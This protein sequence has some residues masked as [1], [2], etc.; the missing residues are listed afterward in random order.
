MNNNPDIFISY[1][2]EDEAKA[3]RLAT[4]L[5]NEGFSVWWD[6][7]LLPAEN[8]RDQIQHALDSSSV[9]VV[10]WTRES[11]GP[12][13]DFV[14]DEAGQA[15]A[16]G[17]LVPVMMEK[18]RLPLGFGELQTVDLIGWRGSVQNVF[19]RDLANAIRAKIEGLPIPKPQGP[20]K[21]LQQRIF[22]SVPPAVL[23]GGLVAFG[24]DL[25]SIQET[26]CSAAFVQ[27]QLSDACGSWGFGGKP[28][29]TER[30]AWEA[31]PQ[32]DCDALRSH[33]EDFPNGSFRDDAA[34][35]LTARRVVKSVIWSPTS[36][37]LN[38]Y[39]GRLRDAEESNERA[40]SVALDEAQ[41]RAEQVC[42][43]F[44]TTETYRLI[45]FGAE[46]A[47]YSCSASTGGFTCSAEGKAICNLQV[48]G[49][50]ENETCGEIT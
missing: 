17:R 34:D 37:S 22:A 48:R 50:V 11:A 20:I 5:E 31:L 47:R 24:A 18:C 39:V 30:L 26:V 38:L 33:I 1:K 12:K 27:P 19:F 41:R 32:G 2:R 25:L 36:K 6:R 16:R 23:V 10:I 45:D 42:G 44:A 40:Q 21:R 9:T 15:K 43:D 8:W 35:M 49:I 29:K 46:V 14:R 4:A 13:G 28:T 7:K 3:A